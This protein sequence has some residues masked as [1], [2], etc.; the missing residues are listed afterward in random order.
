MPHRSGRVHVPLRT[1]GDERRVLGGVIDD[2]I[3]HHPYTARVRGV[4]EPLATRRAF[5]PLFPRMPCYV[6]V[7]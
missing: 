6:Q 1:V 7:L 2:E 3:H 4:D 5:R